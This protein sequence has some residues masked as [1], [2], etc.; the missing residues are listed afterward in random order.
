MKF[1][2]F[3]MFPISLLM[4]MYLVCP[5]R[6]LAEEVYATGTYSMTLKSNCKN[7]MPRKR[8]DYDTAVFE[9]QMNALRTWG[10][11]KSA[12]FTKLISSAESDLVRDIDRYLINP[13]VKTKCEGKDFKVSYRAQVNT[14]AID[15]LMAASSPAEMTGPRSRMTAVFIARKQTSVKIFDEKRVSIEQK[16]NISESEQFA[17][18]SGEGMSA[19]GVDRMTSKTTTGGSVEKKANKIAYDVF[20]S[21]PLDAAVNQN[22]SSFGF[23]VVDASQVSGRFPGFD[24][25]AFR[26]EF[27]VGEDLSPETKNAAFDAITGKIPLLVIAT[28]DVLGSDKDPVTG[29]IVVYA[30][31]KGWVYRDDGL[32]FES[33]AAVAPIQMRGEGPN[34]T[35]AETDAL[36]KAAAAASKE[37]VNQLNAAGIR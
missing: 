36:V 3:L 31:V 4:V 18:V 14:P 12:A 26:E 33:V 10:A 1:L 20:N 35:V 24:L 7:D 21:G 11:G 37:I 5:E 2:N 27:G 8:Q 9:A 28:V 16:E 30:S 15:L 29:N 25:A 34:E 6:A 17:D 23:R 13:Y 22:F 32:F 19:T